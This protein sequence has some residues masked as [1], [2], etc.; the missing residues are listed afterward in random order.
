MGWFDDNKVKKEN[1][2]FAELASKVTSCLNV[3]CDDN[4]KLSII[5]NDATAG[6]SEEEL[7]A[8]N[9]IYDD[10][11]QMKYRS[12]TLKEKYP[13]D[14]LEVDYNDQLMGVSEAMNDM[15]MFVKLN[16]AGYLN[17]LNNEELDA[18][19]KEGVARYA[20]CEDAIDAGV[21][22]VTSE[23]WNK[24]DD[25]T[26][27]MWQTANEYV[28]KTWN[29]GML[30]KG[31]DFE[32]L[33]G[34][35]LDNYT[36]DDLGY[37]SPY[38]N[39][40]N[41]GKISKVNVSVYDGLTKKEENTA[42]HIQ[43]SGSQSEYID[44]RMAERYTDDYLDLTAD[45]PSMQKGFDQISLLEKMND[46]GYINSLSDEEFQ[47]QAKQATVMFNTPPM[48]EGVF[49]VDSETWASADEETRNQYRENSELIRDAWDKKLDEL[50][51]MKEIHNNKDFDLTDDQKQ[52]L[53]NEYSVLA[54]DEKENS[55]SI[56]QQ[57]Q[58]A[59]SGFSWSN[60]KDKVKDCFGAAKEWFESTAVGAW[61]M[62]KIDVAKDKF[63]EILGVDMDKS[64]LIDRTNMSFDVDLTKESSSK[65][66]ELET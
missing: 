53:M 28:L 66:V 45:D 58:A 31:R 59:V 7:K 63:R 62:E 37:F 14:Y 26:K 60:F 6:L 24:A 10:E 11:G 51:V 64:N 4:G 12:D 23:E 35:S 20:E 21:Y 40:D 30:N 49:G 15:I 55:P 22:G 57:A 9:G 61:T 16:D 27:L 8:F 36:R 47:K 33:R 34:E 43:D 25:A 46:P 32:L 18:F 19:L 56:V 38:I 5:R 42:S 50:P 48:S 41:D 1:Q 44:I 3:T 13:D 17:S 52:S 54:L 2:K 39:I 29:E 65:G